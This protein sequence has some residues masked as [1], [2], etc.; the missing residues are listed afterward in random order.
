MKI[1]Q[2]LSLL[3]LLFLTLSVPSIAAVVVNSPAN[4]TS[5]SSPF[6]LS[7]SSA[8]CSSQSVSSMGYSFDSSSATTIISGQSINKSVQ[9][10][11]GTHTLHVKSWGT[12]G[13]SCV[14]DVGITVTGTSLVPS[15]AVSVSSLQSHQTWYAVHDP[16]AGGSSSGS[17]SV[18]N[19]PSRSGF[20]RQFYTTYTSYGGERYH[21]SF[22]DDESATNFVYDTWIYLKDGGSNIANLEFD[23]NQTIPNGHTV[24]FGFQCDGWSSTWDYSMNKGTAASPKGAWVKTSQH[25]N[26]REWTRNAWHHLQ[27]S[28]SRN[29][30]G[31]V[32]YHSVYLDGKQQAVNATAFSAYAL[33]WGSTLLTN[34]QVDGATTAWGSATVLLDNLTVYRW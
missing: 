10:S 14:T 27:V 22:G 11:T 21:T 7:A 31:T 16:G 34:F 5:V 18:V 12:K 15:S 28:Y 30:T 2:K 8:T 6:N 24:I 25:C 20:A 23:L 4:S 33:G 19:S 26:P 29:D 32:T 9:T 1:I 13:A 17:M 3:F